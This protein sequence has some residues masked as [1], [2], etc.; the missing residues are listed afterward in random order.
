MTGTG[1]RPAPGRSRARR[2]LTF[3][4]AL[5]A[6]GSAVALLA[7]TRGWVTVRLPRPSPLSPVVVEGS[8]RTVEPVV[9]ALA[10]VGLAG[11]VGLLATRR[12]GRAVVGAL[13]A[14]AG[15]AVV[16]GAL[17]HL[18]AP[19]QADALTL[20]DAHGPV[21]GLRSDAAV[22]ARSHPLWPVLAACGGLALCTG[23][24]VTLLRSRTWPGMSGRYDR[25]GARGGV[26]ARPARAASSHELWDALDRGE[27]PT[28]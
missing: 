26:A 21:V 10:V 4:L 6:A 15:L 14:A 22:S 24:T 28:G 23:G 17:A 19:S 18:P 12:A 3:A 27:D 11:V 7:A 5:C 9:P 2:E 16:V 25:A 1:E 8:G 13:L 20:L